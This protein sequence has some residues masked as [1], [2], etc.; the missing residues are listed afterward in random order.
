MTS[1]V[2]T[3]YSDWQR[4]Y[5]LQGTDSTPGSDPD[6]DSVPNAV[7]FALMG[8]PLVSDA[9]SILP[10]GSSVTANSQTYAALT[11]K[12][13]KN[14]SGA[15]VLMQTAAALT[16]GAWTTVWTS[17]D[18]AGALVM[19]RVDGSDHWGLTVRDTTSI[20]PALPRRFLR[21]LVSVPR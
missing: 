1:E 3:A 21:L 12:L 7:E 16:N 6:G 5:S 13:R 11:F 9:A 10:T 15:T 2:A 17:A 19:Q 8:S 14:L 20:S 4:A 18:L